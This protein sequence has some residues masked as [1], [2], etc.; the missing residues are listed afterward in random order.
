MTIAVV[1]SYECPSL[2]EATRWVSQLG[3]WVLVYECPI[4]VD[5]TR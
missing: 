4:L 2:V 1:G 5:E 3:G